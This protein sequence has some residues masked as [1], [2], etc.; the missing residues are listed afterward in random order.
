MSNGI[1]ARQNE[2]KS[3]AMLAAQRQLYNEVETLDALNVLSLVILPLITAIFQNGNVPWS[4]IRL[5][6]YVLSFAVL[7]ISVS[8]QGP[9]NI[10]SHSRH[11]S[12]W[13]LTYMYILCLGIRS[14]LE[15]KRT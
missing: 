14:S 3:I 2:D 4:G 5:I 11:Q 12:S 6:P 7:L 9:A 8:S 15:R 1:S 10:K 13:L